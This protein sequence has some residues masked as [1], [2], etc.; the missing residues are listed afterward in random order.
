M[1]AIDIPRPFI[2]EAEEPFGPTMTTVRI[3]LNALLAHTATH[4]T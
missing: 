1:E 3:D 4:R 2:V